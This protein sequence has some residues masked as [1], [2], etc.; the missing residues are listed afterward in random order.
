M[1]Q[2]QDVY[3]K[4]SELRNFGINPTHIIASYRKSTK[5]EIK[6]EELVKVSANEEANSINLETFD[7][8]TIVVPVYSADGSYNK[9]E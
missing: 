3:I 5:R 7:K 4:I 2:N 8:I 9:I 6:I 1:D